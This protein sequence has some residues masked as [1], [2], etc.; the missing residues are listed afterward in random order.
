M[1]A[2]ATAEQPTR[3]FL[4]SLGSSE[5]AMNT[6]ID[7]PGTMV[8]DPGFS[9]GAPRMRTCALL[10]RVAAWTVTSAVP[11]FAGSGSSKNIAVAFCTPSPASVSI[12]VP[13]NV[14]WEVDTVRGTPAASG[15]A[16]KFGDHASSTQI[17]FARYSPAARCCRTG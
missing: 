15:P 16:E 11:S 12:E 3:D 1:F 6:V 2:E 13:S 14:P 8:V 10:V 7:I 4:T 17:H 5:L 9:V